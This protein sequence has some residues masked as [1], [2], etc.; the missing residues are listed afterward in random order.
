VAVH[1]KFSIQ[2]EVLTRGEADLFLDQID[3]VYDLGDGMLDLNSGVRLHEIELFLGIHQEFERTETA[4]VD[5]IRGVFHRFNDP[6][7]GFLIDEG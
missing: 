1:L 2:G 5:E 3:T 4:I 6:L 7:T